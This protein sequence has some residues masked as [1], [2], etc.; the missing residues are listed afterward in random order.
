MKNVL[1]LFLVAVLISGCITTE[2]FDPLLSPGSIFSQATE[3]DRFQDLKLIKRGTELFLESDDGCT[4][5]RVSGNPYVE[6]GIF[7]KDGKYIVY[8]TSGPEAKQYSSDIIDVRAEGFFLQSVEGEQDSGRAITF[9][10]YQA[11]VLEKMS[12]F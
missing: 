6:G 12:S 3:I 11:F 1:F 7:T 10:E 9:E 4:R 8:L 2:E 5:R